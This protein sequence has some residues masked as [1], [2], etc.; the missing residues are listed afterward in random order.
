MATQLSK[1]SILSIKV[2]L[3]DI[4]KFTQALYNDKDYPDKE[5]DYESIK[6]RVYEISNII[7]SYEKTATATPGLMRDI[8]DPEYNPFDVFN[9]IIL[10]VYKSGT[11]FESINDPDDKVFE[12]IKESIEE[13]TLRESTITLELYPKW[14][15]C[16]TIDYSDYLF[17]SGNGDIG[18]PIKG[19]S[20]NLQVLLFEKY[21]SRIFPDGSVYVY[22]REDCSY[23]YPEKI[24]YL[25]FKD[26]SDIIVDD[27][28]A[29]K[30]EDYPEPYVNT[31]DDISI[32]VANAVYDIMKNTTVSY[33][34]NRYTVSW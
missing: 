15:K 28:D 24:T 27:Y 33:I 11:V 13:H 1:V 9:V 7:C 17:N 20:G 26:S 6:R 12:K 10:P 2:L 32:R 19:L 30:D 4:T 14:R 21:I 25:A 34:F 31:K 23:G 29:E 8:N 18:F 22:T 3:L 5:K 16:I